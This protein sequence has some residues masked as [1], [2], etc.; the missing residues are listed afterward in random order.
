MESKCQKLNN[1]YSVKEAKKS[2]YILV[3]I[4]VYALFSATLSSAATDDSSELQINP[5]LDIPLISAPV[6]IDGDVSDWGD[7]GLRRSLTVLLNSTLEHTAE[8]FYP[9][10][11]VAWCDKGIL[12]FIS[13]MDDEV[14]PTSNP[15]KCD[16]GDGIRLGLHNAAGGDA[17]LLDLALFFQKGKSCVFKMW[18]LKKQPEKLREIKFEAK[19]SD[20][21]YNIEMLLPWSCLFI[22]KTPKLEDVVNLQIIVRDADSGKSRSTLKRSWHPR[23][24]IYSGDWEYTRP[25]RLSEKSSELLDAIGSAQYRDGKIVLDINA[26]KDLSGKKFT[27]KM[28]G[29]VVAEGVLKKSETK[30]VAK[31]ISLP[32][33]KDILLKELLVSIDDKRIPCFKNTDYTP[34]ALDFQIIPKKLADGSTSCS[35][36]IDDPPEDLTLMN[37]KIEVLIVNKKSDEIIFYQKIP[38]DEKIQ[39]PM[40]KKGRFRIM[41]FLRDPLSIGAATL[42][43]EDGEIVPRKQCEKRLVIVIPAALD[44]RNRSN[45]ASF[46]NSINRMISSSLSKKYDC[47]M[48]NRAQSLDMKT[49]KDIGNVSAV[50][51]GDTSIELP[52]ADYIVTIRLQNPKKQTLYDP[53]LTVE[54]FIYSLENRDVPVRKVSSPIANIDILADLVAHELGL[55]K[56]DKKQTQKST[57][58]LKWAVLPFFNLADRKLFRTMGGLDMEMPMLVELAMQNSTAPVDLVDHKEMRKVLDE[59][60]MATGGVS[61]NSVS[62]IAKIMKADRALLF[63]INDI[64]RCIN[65]RDLE[66]VDALVIDPAT[67]AII[68]A[69]SAISWHGNIAETAAT[70]AEKLIARNPE[71]KTLQP[72][73]KAMRHR[74]TELLI[75]EV[76]NT[77]N[78]SYFPATW[79]AFTLQNLES[80]Y[81]LGYDNPLLMK[82][83]IVQLNHLKAFGK[84]S[85][86]G[87]KAKFV[88]LAQ[89]ALKHTTASILKMDPDMKMVAILRYLGRDAEAIKLLRKS[90]KLPKGKKAQWAGR[91]AIELLIKEYTKVKEYDKALEILKNFYWRDIF[92]HL[93][94]EIYKQTSQEGK[95]FTFLEQLNWKFFSHK[96]KNIKGMR[97]RTKVAREYI[98]IAKKLKG[99][100]YV[101]KVLPEKIPHSVCASEQIAFELAKVK[102]EFGEVENLSTAALYL[103]AVNNARGIREISYC[104]GKSSKEIKKEIKDLLTKTKGKTDPKYMKYYKGREVNPMP[105][106]LKFYLQPFGV[107]SLNKLKK[108]APLLSDYFGTEVVVLNNIPL[109]EDISKYFNKKLGRYDLRKLMY[110]VGEKAKFPDDAIFFLPI[111]DLECIASC[112]DCGKVHKKTLKQA[113]CIKDIGAV[114]SFSQQRTSINIAKSVA[115]FFEVFVARF[116]KYQGLKRKNNAFNALCPDSIYSAN[117]RYLDKSWQHLK[118]GMAHESTKHYENIDFK[119]VKAGMDKTIKRIKSKR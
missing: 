83:L 20:T 116:Y 61:F 63:S 87:Q 30:A 65:E 79:S 53:S 1:K 75:G 88:Y 9:T 80:A 19:K 82:K 85:A 22:K 113:L 12:V 32:L 118:L 54:M 69:E 51:K 90:G 98:N 11:R 8:D 13:V 3:L 58:N 34:T 117:K 74:E 39:L 103:N 97:L 44:C 16:R 55:R 91:H 50:I 45:M 48:L 41:A 112:S 105:K 52:A 40:E 101:D 107:K 119:V 4:F 64:S 92:P 109:P 21:G 18:A 31:N 72:A 108:A 46:V 35:F 68:D 84:R 14:V 89:Q 78:Y 99:A 86:P 76:D 81:A 77:G 38:Y 43:V 36:T 33:P 70:L 7:K 28:M 25:L 26:A 56:K 37:P 57:G 10:T 5:V 6:K 71:V 23:N 47:T 59:I 100:Q 29:K 94:I 49:E 73:T 67:N 104:T 111:T 17:N 102:I 96:N 110:F 106:N 114:I 62:S 66:R 95:L 27:A 60:T 93:Y 15:E 2:V 115:K 42:L 24:Y